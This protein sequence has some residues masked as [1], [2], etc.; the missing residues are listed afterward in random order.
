MEHNRQITQG[1]HVLNA[2]TP[3]GAQYNRWRRCLGP[4]IPGD[5]A[6]AK[7]APKFNSGEIRAKARWRRSAGTWQP[8]TRT[9]IDESRRPGDRPFKFLVVVGSIWRPDRLERGPS[10]A[11]I[12]RMNTAIP[13]VM[14]F[15]W[16]Q[17]VVMMRGDSM[18]D[19][20][21]RGDF[22]LI[23]TTQT[24]IAGGGV[25]AILEE[26]RSLIIYQVEAS[27]PGRIRC[28]PRDRQNISAS[29]GE[30]GIPPLG[31]HHRLFRL[32]I[33]PDSGSGLA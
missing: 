28:T 27:G 10:G 26:N 32:A 12:E 13:R 15:T 4:Q 3:P 8:A 17:A 16:D 7:I 29:G 9:R 18:G 22:A 5:D 6:A 31:R 21:R 33:R 30:S 11:H 14:Y 19:T 25:F 24:E 20:L 23:D 1:V 2:T